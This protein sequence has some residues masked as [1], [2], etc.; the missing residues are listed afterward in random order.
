VKFTLMRGDLGWA[1]I[2]PT[3]RWHFYVEGGVSACK[4]RDASDAAADVFTPPT[5]TETP[6]P[7]DCT[8]CWEKL[9]KRPME[10]AS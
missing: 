5:G 7:E 2:P 3:R 4:T 10:P 1:L 8:A 6:A 9:R